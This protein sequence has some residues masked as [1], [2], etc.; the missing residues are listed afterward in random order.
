MSFNK[1]TWDKD[2]T[3]ANGL[4]KLAAADAQRKGFAPR[5][6]KVKGEKK[7]GQ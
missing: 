3:G 5:K 1:N 4:K 7:D 2:Y 6:K